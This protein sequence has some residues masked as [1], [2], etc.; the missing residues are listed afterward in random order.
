MNFLNPAAL[1]WAALAIPIIGFYIL[2]IRLRRVPVSTTMFWSQIF[3]QKQPR[4][5]WQH[6]RHLF[7]L[8]VQ[9]AVLALLVFSLAEPFFRWDAQGARRIVLILDNSASMNATDRLPSRLSAAKIEGLR[10]IDNLR[11]TDEMA[12]LAAGTEPQV[13]CGLTDHQSTLRAALEAIPATEGPTRVTRAIAL[14][15]KLLEGQKNP[16]IVVLTDGGFDEAKEL[17]S[18]KNVSLIPFSG[19]TPNLGITRFQTRR[20]LVDPIGYEILAEVTNASDKPIHARLEIDLNNDPIDVIPLKLEPGQIWNQTFDKASKEGGKLTA[21]LSK[22]DKSEPFIDA[23]LADNQSIALLPKREPQPV[24]LVSPGNHFLA[25]VFEAIPLVNL[26]TTK[27][28]PPS[29]QR[30][31]GGVT[32]YHKLLP[33]KLP[34]GPVLVIDPQGPTELWEIGEKLTSPIVAKQDKDSPFLAHVRLD[35]VG[36]PDAR[37]IEPKGQAKILAQSLAGEPLLLVFDRPE[38][39]VVVLTVD[40]DQSELPLQTAFPILMTNAMAEFAGQKGE[41]REAI[42]T[43]G[44]ADV[45]LIGTAERVLV[46]PDGREK[47]LPTGLA[48]QS[49]GPLD[50]CGV[51]SIAKRDPSAKT[52]TTQPA[53]IEIAAN[54]SDRRESDLRPPTDWKPSVAGSS[55]GLGG[56]PIWYYLIALAWLLVG[57]EWFLYQRRWIS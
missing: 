23:L 7:S 47:P 16:R 9:L 6:L 43:G 2:K 51:W 3:E 50:A 52:G 32:V 10:M 31:A 38:G 26:T 54:L 11:F 21:K 4:S 20:S 18:E 35:N 14:A 36:L 56:R 44:V 48:K 17:A 15:R 24:M 46:A 37:K 8:L 40:L 42:S 13:A 22:P 19:N 1:A 25:K 33:Q 57:L 49:V 45:E 29:M 55:G 41:L 53:E 28:I 12:I 5:I 39:P 34:A 27:V 30:P